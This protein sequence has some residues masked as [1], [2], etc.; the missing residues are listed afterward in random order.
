MTVEHYQFT[1]N[2]STATEITGIIP[3]GKR[4]RNGLSIILNTNKNNNTTVFIGGATVTS[5]SFGYH[6]DS[7]ETLNLSGLYDATDRLYA[8]AGSGSPILH[9]LV[10][11]K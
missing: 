3:T 6:M 2:T 1:L 7:D 9:V 4:K 5:S 11:G 8:I 10:V